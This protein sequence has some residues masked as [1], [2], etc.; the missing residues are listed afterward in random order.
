MV[1]NHVGQI[2]KYSSLCQKNLRTKEEC[3]GANDSYIRVCMKRLM[4]RGQEKKGI[5]S[6]YVTIK[7]YI[8]FLILFM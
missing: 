1:F 7:F 8:D 3:I 5:F 4:L 6:S 2:R